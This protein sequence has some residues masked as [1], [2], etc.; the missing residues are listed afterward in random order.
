[1]L[2][3]TPTKVMSLLAVAMTSLVFLFMV[4]VTN[5]SFLGTQNSV[6]D[7]VSPDKVMAVLDASAASYSNFLSQN[8]F[9]PAIQSYALAS[10]N[11][12][13]ISSNAQTGLYAMLGVQEQQPAPIE[14]AQTPIAG[15]V[16]GA[17]TTRTQS[18]WY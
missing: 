1:M 4:T 13:W 14:V 10:E 8:L 2:E 15:R 9:T 18:P 11:I 6:I 3:E 16:A 17:E 7:P 12:S 5:A